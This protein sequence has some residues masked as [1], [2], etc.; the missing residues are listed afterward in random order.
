MYALVLGSLRNVVSGLAAGFP[1]V[2]LFCN[3]NKPPSR[4]GCFVALES[5]LAG[6]VFHAFGSGNPL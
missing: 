2:I 1:T 3:F 6:T 5:L 4:D